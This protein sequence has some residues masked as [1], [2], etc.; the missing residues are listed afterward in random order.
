[1]P[2]LNSLRDR[3]AA[4]SDRL[5]SGGLWRRLKTGSGRSGNRFELDGRRVRIFADND[6]LGLSEDPKTKEAATAALNKFGNSASSSRLISGNHELYANLEAE[7]AA[8]KNRESALVFPSGYMAN[9]GVLTTL[10]DRGDTIHMDRFNHAS[11]YDAVKLSDAKLDRYAHLDTAEL[12]ASLAETSAGGA[13]V[14][15]GI[16]S[17][18][19]DLADLPELARLGA[20]YDLPLVVDD[21]H[22][23]GV[24]GPSGA[25]TAAHLKI[26]PTVEVGTLSKA[27]GALGGFVAGDR[28][29]IE[30]LINKARP[31]IFTTGLPPATVAAATAAVRL[32]RSEPWRQERLL[33]SAKRVRAELSAAGI[34]VPVGITPIIPII[35]GEASTASA[36]CDACLARGVFVPAVRP[37][38]VPP[39]SSRLRLTISAAHSR[40]DIDAVIEAVVDSATEMGLI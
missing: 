2:K 31:F 8:L 20:E 6:Y 36:L 30:L 17:M 33:L 14:T 35:V 3:M 21:A 12:Q 37:P 10:A 34:S 4:E 27:V 28:D 13:I 40:S 23:T 32:I 7:L 29:F 25:G 24:I 9:L 39:G 1:M 38:A 11:L 15:D 19:G 5:K 26:K 16:F 22:G 18:D